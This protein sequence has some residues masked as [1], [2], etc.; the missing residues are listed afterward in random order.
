LTQEEA[1]KQFDSLKSLLKNAKKSDGADLFTHFQKV[2]KMLIL[3]YPKQA[4]EKLEEVSYLIKN[5]ETHKLS[6]FLKTE[7]IR[8]YKLR[9]QDLKPYN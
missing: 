4:L 2:F 6:D 9:A 5:E 1:F 7:D 3:H 8:N